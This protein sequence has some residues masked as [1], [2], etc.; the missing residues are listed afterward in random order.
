MAD[1]AQK[2][3]GSKRIRAVIDRIEDGETAVVLTGDDGEISFDVPVALL[4]KGAGDGDHLQITFALDKESRGEAEAR[5]KALQERLLK[6]SAG[7]SKPDASG[8]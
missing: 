4:P 5:V 1:E 2:T 6:R 8:S 7:G 3:E